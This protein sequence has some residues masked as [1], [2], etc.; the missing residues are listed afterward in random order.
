MIC[1]SSGAPSVPLDFRC[2]FCQILWRLAAANSSAVSHG[3]RQVPWGLVPSASHCFSA[4]TPSPLLFG[5]ASC[6]PSHTWSQQDDGFLLATL[7][8]WRTLLGRKPHAHTN[9]TQL[10]QDLPFRFCLL[11]VTLQRLESLF[12]SLLCFQI[13]SLWFWAVLPL[14]KAKR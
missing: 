14:H 5:H 12:I 8:L 1:C 2:C 3:F 6:L 7:H 9:F 11:L 4:S 10:G 13:S